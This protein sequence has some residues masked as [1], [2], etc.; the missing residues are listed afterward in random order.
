[1]LISVII[2]GDDTR[3][4]YRMLPHRERERQKERENQLNLFTIF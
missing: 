1:M 4:I 2:V 3:Y